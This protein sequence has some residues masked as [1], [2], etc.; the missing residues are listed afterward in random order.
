MAKQSFKQEFR[1]GVQ[2]N[3][4][5]D[6]Q[7]RHQPVCLG[8]VWWLTHSRDIGICVMQELMLDGDTS[9]LF[10]VA[11]GL[12]GLQSMFGTI[13]H[14]YGKGP[15]AAAV[16]AMLTSMRKEQGSSTVSPAGASVIT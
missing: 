16:K 1:N 13:P 4:R 10:Y 6:V 7:R 11:R 14:I 3:A 15:N 8:R 2:C 9:S 5:A 12:M